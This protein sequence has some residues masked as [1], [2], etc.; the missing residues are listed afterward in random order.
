MF[1]ATSRLSETSLTAIITHF[2]T[3]NL[4]RNQVIYR[5]G[6][7]ADNLYFVQHGEIIV[8]IFLKKKRD[9]SF[10]CS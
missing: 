4:Q 9:S 3:H 1:P 7:P 8:I 2:N 6:D 10:N 5:E